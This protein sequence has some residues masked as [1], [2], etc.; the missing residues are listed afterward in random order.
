MEIKLKEIA[1]I[2]FGYYGKPSENGSLAYLQAKHFNDYGQYAEESDAF[3]V[4]DDKTITHLLQNDD[5]LFV[6]KG[7]RFFAALYKKEIGN[8]VASSIFYI[9]RVD[10]S[11][12]IPEY[13]VSVL[14]LPKNLM[15]FQQSASGS[16]IPSIRKNELEDFSLNLISI[17]EQ[18]SVVALQELYFNDIKI[19]E[20]LIKEKKALFQTT[21]SKII[22]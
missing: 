5:I 20:A 9:L 8:A 12:I 19:T 18:R 14:N 13:L 2:Q 4:E 11:R 16:S 7:F 22:K 17:E 1:E 3:L 15:Y 10:Q 21:I 6:A